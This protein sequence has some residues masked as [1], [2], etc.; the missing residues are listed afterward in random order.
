MDT[1]SL[2]SYATVDSLSLASTVTPYPTTYRSHHGSELQRSGICEVEAG[3]EEEYKVKENGSPNPILPVHVT[4]GGNGHSPNPTTFPMS[5]PQNGSLRTD[6]VK[7]K[8]G[9]EAV[10]NGVPGTAASQ[11]QDM[12]VGPEGRF[13]PL[14]FPSKQTNAVS[15]N[16]SDEEVQP[17]DF[18]RIAHQGAA[19]KMGLHRAREVRESGV[20]GNRKDSAKPEALEER[21]R[22]SYNSFQTHSAQVPTHRGDGGSAG[23]HED[24]SRDGMMTLSNSPHRTTDEGATS[25]I[26]LQTYQTEE[27]PSAQV[28]T[29]AYDAE[30]DRSRY[31]P[32]SHPSVT[33]IPHH[34]ALSLGLTSNND[35]TEPS[36]AEA[37]RP[38]TSDTSHFSADQPSLLRYTHSTSHYRDG[39]MMKSDVA[40]PHMVS[41]YANS[42]AVGAGNGEHADRTAVRVTSSQVSDSDTQFLEDFID[43]PSEHF[44]YGGTRPLRSRQ[45]VTNRD[46]RPFS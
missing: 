20:K 32:E 38:T 31:Q 9:E 43:G 37:S 2:N 30:G 8:R 15:I 11:T 18:S 40:T 12:E 42:A 26:E 19:R 35:N 33:L 25:V 16:A 7:G 14:Q 44:P 27:T 24:I 6:D 23:C 10:G 46:R 41:R 13:S 3:E 1:M 5:F 22:S 45:Q 29:T 17:L 28:R 4:H 36:Q 21:E 39:A 34:L